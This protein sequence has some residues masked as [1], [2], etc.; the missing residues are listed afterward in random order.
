MVSNH[1]YPGLTGDR[2]QALSHCLPTHDRS[3]RRNNTWSQQVSTSC[4]APPSSVYTQSDLM[5]NWW[6][7]VCTLLRDQTKCIVSPIIHFKW[8]MVTITWLRLKLLA[9]RLTFLPHFLLSRE[10]DTVIGRWSR[11][12]RRVAWQR[13]VTGETATALPLSLIWNN[14][15]CKWCNDAAQSKR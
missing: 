14:A 9:I 8:Q 15:F 10:R 4:H 5:I 11:D 7:I 1:Y 13:N 12:A 3:P 6:I 2:H